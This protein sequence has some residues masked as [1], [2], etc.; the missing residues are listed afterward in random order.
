MTD[1]FYPQIIKKLYEGIIHMSTYTQIHEA[2]KAKDWQLN[3]E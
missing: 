3:F 2:N 1:K